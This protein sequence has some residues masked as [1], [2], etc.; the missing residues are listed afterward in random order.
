MAKFVTLTAP[1]S[2]SPISV[3]YRNL[4]FALMPLLNS[5]FVPRFA[6][7]LVASISS[8]VNKLQNT[9]IFCQYF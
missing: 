8:T 5:V 3:P 2:E 9:T 7:W 6:L 1:N 4:P